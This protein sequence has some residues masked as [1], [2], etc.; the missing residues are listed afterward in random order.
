[1]HANDSTET[2]DGVHVFLLICNV[3]V[4]SIYEAH[5]ENPAPVQVHAQK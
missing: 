5:R 2:T 4:L 1:M 3:C